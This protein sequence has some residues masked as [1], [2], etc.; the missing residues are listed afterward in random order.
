MT[1][2]NVGNVAPSTSKR[3]GIPSIAI[4]N[5]AVTPGKIA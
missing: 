1:A 5:R 4:K 3:S 2:G